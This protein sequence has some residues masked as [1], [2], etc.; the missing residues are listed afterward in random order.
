MT[1][2][3]IG[4]SASG[5]ETDVLSLEGVGKQRGGGMTIYQLPSFFGAVLGRG[6]DRL[7][8]MAHRAH[9]HEADRM[10][11]GDRRRLRGEHARRLLVSR[12][13]LDA[14]SHVLGELL[15]LPV[16]PLRRGDR[17]RHHVAQRD[18]D[19]FRAGRA[20]PTTANAFLRNLDGSGSIWNLTGTLGVAVGRHGAPRPGSHDPACPA[21]RSSRAGASSYQNVDN[22]A[23]PWNQTFFND[24]DATFDYRLPFD[25]NV[26][27]AWRSKAFEVEAD[28]RYHGAIS[29]YY[30]LSSSKPVS[31]TTT[32]A[33]TETRSTRPSRSPE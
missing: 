29:E 12:R 21:S 33:G 8:A 20:A 31:I 15:P 5:F 13:P 9:H 27:L 30:L 17:R 22:R 26:G 25:V 16:A 23:T 2:T 32:D 19:P 7:R 28:L 24:Q 1:R 18:P 14:H 3:A 10:E 11:P 4:A 6:R